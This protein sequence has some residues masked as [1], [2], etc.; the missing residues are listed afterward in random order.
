MRVR[1]AIRCEAGRCLISADY[2]QIEMRVLA[3]CCGDA[4]LRRVFAQEGQSDVYALIAAVLRREPVT[5]VTPQQ[6]DEAKVITL[7]LCYGMGVE[8]MAAK[9]GIA[10]KS[11]MEL[12]T[13][14]LRVGRGGALLPRNTAAF[15]GSSARRWPAPAS[16]TP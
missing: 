12:R 8:S 3:M 10:P 6:R 4:E 15:S 2:R 13:E 16:S 11:A 7:G 1:E 5:A 9:L 14:I